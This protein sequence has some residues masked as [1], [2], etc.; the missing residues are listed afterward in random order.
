MSIIY[1]YLERQ[2]IPYCYN[3]FE[4]HIMISEQFKLIIEIL[5]VKYKP[6]KNYEK[7]RPIDYICSPRRSIVREKI[8]IDQA[9]CLTE[10]SSS[11][12]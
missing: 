7:T 3:A 12:P 1:L 11:E 4:Y 5:I 6:M 2:N 8:I 10:L 9:N